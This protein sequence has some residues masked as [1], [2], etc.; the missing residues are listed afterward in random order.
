MPA[1]GRKGR[2]HLLALASSFVFVL[3]V[4]M[5]FQPGRQWFEAMMCMAGWD[6]CSHL[7]FSL[8]IIGVHRLGGINEM[9]RFSI[10]AMVG[11]FF[12]HLCQRNFI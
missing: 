10:M 5:F 3:G 12:E 6:K 11:Y 2:A 8:T 1:C 9:K 7:F 4:G